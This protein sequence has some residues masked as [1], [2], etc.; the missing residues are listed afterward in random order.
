MDDARTVE[1]G[2]RHRRAGTGGA[3]HD[4][5][6][7]VM[8]AS[9]PL[10]DTEA[11]RRERIHRFGCPEA[12]DGAYE[13]RDFLGRTVVELDGTPPESDEQAREL[14]GV[15][16]LADPRLPVCVLPTGER[17]EAATGASVGGAPCS[18]PGPTS[19]SRGS[20]PTGPRRRRSR[21]G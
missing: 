19:D 12:D 4:E 9:I 5:E 1:R 13:I 8:T 16:D 10:V 21:S 18:R 6:Q 3:R 17:V 2:R 14:A 20:L 15:D 11:V 7:S